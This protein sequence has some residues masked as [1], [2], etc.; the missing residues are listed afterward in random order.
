MAQNGARLPKRSW[1]ALAQ[2]DMVKQL[3][4]SNAKQHLPD[5]SDEERQ[6]LVDETLA[7]KSQ[8]LATV[9]EILACS[10]MDSH[11]YTI[12]HLMPLPRIF[13]GV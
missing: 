9:S 8:V 4:L 11:H 1:P 13:V 6:A 5:R 12:R 7:D 2:D 10:G 3:A